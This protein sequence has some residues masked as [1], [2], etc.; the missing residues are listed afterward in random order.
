MKNQRE[1]TMDNIWIQLD[2]ENYSFFALAKGII[3]KTEYSVRPYPCSGELLQPKMEQL[4]EKA[5]PQFYYVSNKEEQDIL[6]GIWSPDINYGHDKM[7]YG[8]YFV[9]LPLKYMENYFQSWFCNKQVDALVRPYY[10]SSN[11][12]VI[13]NKRLLVTAVFIILHE[14]G[15][16]LDY[17]RLGSKE[18]YCQWTYNAKKQFREYEDEL[19][20]LST[21]QI[22]TAE[23]LN[24][25]DELYR[26]CEDEHSADLY[27]LDNL[28]SKINEALHQISNG[29]FTYQY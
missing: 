22:I 4:R 23:Q 1:R 28:D 25:R 2:I 3:P 29:L 14:Y 18:K 9:D 20:K 8:F 10:V 21:K 24:R 12:L 15:H 17:K 6:S 7:P 19:T 16:Y 11:G 27:A 26:L 5:I 13:F